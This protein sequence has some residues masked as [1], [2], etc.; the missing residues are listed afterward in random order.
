M[1]CFE[2]LPH[3][4]IL[5]SEFVT[6]EAQCSHGLDDACQFIAAN[7]TDIDQIFQKSG[8]TL[9]PYLKARLEA[10]DKSW[11]TSL[12]ERLTS[13]PPANWKEPTAKVLSSKLF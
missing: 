5:S 4:L 7:A 12:L 8:Y 2:V 11:L 9:P 13:A 6:A 10:K 3:H 1:V